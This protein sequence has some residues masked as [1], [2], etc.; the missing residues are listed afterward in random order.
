MW[1]LEKM[2]KI[3]QIQKRIVS[4]ETFCGNLVVRLKKR[5]F[6]APC[7]TKIM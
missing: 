5:P 6:F 1:K 3:L 4:L 7:E 2:I